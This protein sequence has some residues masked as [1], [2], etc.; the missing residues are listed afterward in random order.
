MKRVYLASRF[1][2]QAELRGYR[3]QLIAMGV[4]VTSSWLDVE[5]DEAAGAYTDEQLAEAAEKN[6][7]DIER[8]D[9][10]IVFTD[11]D[12]GSRRGGH[13]VELG[14]AFADG[15]DIA[16]VGPR[17]NVFHY[18]GDV[19]WFESWD[20]LLATADEVKDVA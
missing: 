1:G 2:R 11:S 10:L 3:E 9:V 20:E 19:N 8:A 16:V 17:V 13:H 15:K 4:E 12:E 6:F 18:H 5:R 14:F 7:T